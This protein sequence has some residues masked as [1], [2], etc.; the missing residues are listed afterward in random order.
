MSG[1]WALNIPGA[2][3]DAPR[4]FVW[5][6]DPHRRETVVGLGVGPFEGYRATVRRHPISQ[7]RQWSVVVGGVSVASGTT[8][9]DEMGEQPT[10]FEAEYNAWR[11]RNGLS[12]RPDLA[13]DW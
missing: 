13:P 6:R 12:T 9:F 1:Y 5:E 4:R 11:H 8:W 10:M 2:W 3:I 7:A